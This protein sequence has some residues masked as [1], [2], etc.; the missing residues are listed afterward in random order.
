MAR[1]CACL[2]SSPISIGEGPAPPP[3]LPPPPPPKL[4]IAASIESFNAERSIGSGTG[5]I[6]D[7]VAVSVVYEVVIAGTLWCSS[8]IPVVEGVDGGGASA[9]GGG[10][11]AGTGAGAVEEVGV[12]VATLPSS[13]VVFVSLL[14]ISRG[15]LAILSFN[16]F[17][18]NNGQMPQ[19]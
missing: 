3:W 13:L 5:S 14:S 17:V 2:S 11:T 18:V 7:A 12:T 4:A 1:N 10:I 8:T 19:N 15:E 6:D 9:T 16:S